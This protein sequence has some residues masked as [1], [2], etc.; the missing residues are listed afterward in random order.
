MSNRFFPPLFDPQ[1]LKSIIGL[2][3]YTVGV[4]IKD[5]NSGVGIKSIPSTSSS[6]LHIPLG[7]V[8]AVVIFT[9]LLRALL[10]LPPTPPEHLKRSPHETRGT[11]TRFSLLIIVHRRAGPQLS[12]RTVERRVDPQPGV[13][14]IK[15]RVEPI[16]HDVSQHKEQ[17]K[18]EE[19][20]GHH[21]E[22]R[23]DTPHGL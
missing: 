5:F 11:Q 8:I 2:G 4:K 20:K 7:V 19:P 12:E 21:V 22:R 9:Y 10:R 6:F 3:P 17:Q 18:V 14:L 15:P 13:F 23:R 16:C 1:S